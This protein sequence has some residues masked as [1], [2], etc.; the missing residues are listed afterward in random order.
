MDT[1]QK[2]IAAFSLTDIYEMEVRLSE[3]KNRFSKADRKYLKNKLSER[4]SSDEIYNTLI[5]Y[6]YFLGDEGLQELRRKEGRFGYWKYFDDIIYKVEKSVSCFLENADFLQLSEA[7]IAY[8]QKK[9]QMAWLGEYFRTTQNDID[10]IIKKH[11]GES[12]TGILDGQ[13]FETS[14][15]RELIAYIDLLFLQ[16]Y[17]M[18]AK[19]DS[20]L[21]VIESYSNEDIASAVSFLIYRY[22]NVIGMPE[23]NCWIDAD[24]VLSDELKV[25][26]LQACKFLRLREWELFWDYYGYDI[27]NNGCFYPPDTLMGKSI[28]LG[29]INTQMQEM[30]F[31]TRVY[32]IGE[33]EHYAALELYGE[34]LHKR[35]DAASQ[36]IIKQG[37]GVFERYI[38]KTPNLL[39]QKIGA[40]DGGKYPL[41]LEEMTLLQYMEKELALSVEKLIDMKVS[42]SATLHDVIMFQRIFQ[43]NRMYYSYLLKHGSDIKVLI[44]SMGQMIPAATMKSL[45]NSQINNMT[46]TNEIIDFFTYK[47]DRYD[48]QYTPLIRIG[49]YYCCPTVICARSNFIHNSLSY[50]YQAGI[51]NKLDGEGLENLCYNSFEQHQDLFSVQRG[52][53]YKYHGDSGEIDLLVISDE[54]I[55]FIECKNPLLPTSAF[56]MRTT[57]DYLKKASSQLDCMINS[58]SDESFQ[59]QYLHSIGIEFKKRKLLTCIVLGTRLFSGYDGFGHPIRCIHELR[60]F[61]NDGCIHFVYGDETTT[62]R[63]WCKEKLSLYDIEAYLSGDNYPTK[64]FQLDMM[65]PYEQKMS[66]GNHT[67]KFRTYKLR[68]PLMQKNDAEYPLKV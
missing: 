14:L 21:D 18:M 66:C 44:R 59:K 32:K 7:Q 15:F 55:L 47:G 17:N 10:K 54:F 20:N 1:I 9:N 49:D 51:Y 64:N 13:S 50:L 63:I 6:V 35:E 27:S 29:Y 48:I 52:K 28:M 2:I 33:M 37:K 36:M 43:L 4:N 11:H 24:Y 57:F 53:K 30:L 22:T 3:Y 56:N 68:T 46:K 19:D 62:K 31:C 26:I 38:F 58:F 41:Y 45:L 5:L 42:K 34:M 39:F 67:V 40:E 61:L 65:I 23:I 25:L 8:F 16:R 60:T 12:K